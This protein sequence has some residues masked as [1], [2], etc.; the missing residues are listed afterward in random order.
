MRIENEVRILGDQ[1]FDLLGNPQKNRIYQSITGSPEFGYKLDF[2]IEDEK[3]SVPITDQK[4]REW[5]NQKKA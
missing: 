2:W 5:E 4:V 3:F 1:V